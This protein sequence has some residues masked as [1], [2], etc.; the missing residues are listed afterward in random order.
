M[1]NS[2]KNIVLRGSAINPSASSL[3]LPIASWTAFA[4]SFSNNILSEDST[5]QQHAIYIPANAAP[6][7]I[8]TPYRW[9]IWVRPL[10]RRFCYTTIAPNGGLSR[11][12][13]LWGLDGQ[14]VLDQKTINSNPTSI[15]TGYK[16]IGADVYQLDFLFTITSGASNQVP[17]IG[18]ADS[19]TPTYTASFD[20][21]YQGLNQASIQVL[22]N[23]CIPI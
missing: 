5:N 1:R 6:L 3:F 9:R 8:N 17:V 14:G 2:V 13:L 19:A 4:A 22:A 21:R 23:E 12:V 20:V 18:A 7:S 10:N 15:S 11:V 16:K